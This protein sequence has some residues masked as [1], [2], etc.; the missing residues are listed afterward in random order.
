MRIFIRA[1][2]GNSIGLGHIMR[3]LV[4][5]KEL[6][7]QN[8]QVIYICRDKEKSDKYKTGIQKI[9]EEN[10]QVIKI[11]EN[12]FITEIINIQKDYNAD[13]IITD[14]YDVNEEYFDI[15][16]PYFKLTGYIDDVNKCRM[17]VDFILNQNINANDLDY[18]R[19]VKSKT[20]LFLGTKY[21]LIR[22]EFRKAYKKKIINLEADKILLTLGGMDNNHNTI[23][24]LN[25]MKEINKKI[26]VVIGTA[27]SRELIEK[28][29]YLS[30]ENNNIIPCE[31]ANMSQLML[32]CDAAVSACGST[33]YE[34]AAMKVP[35]I[36]LIVAD[37]QKEV[38]EKMIENS[39][40]VDI[41]DINKFNQ[42]EFLDSVQKC[43][44]DKNLRRSIINKMKNIV[45]INGAENILYEINKFLK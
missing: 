5:A 39:L 41:F 19:N 20:K 36:G 21:C 38:A 15:L 28:I 43:I 30:K 9:I 32:E 12:N 14:S 1:D 44:G 34:L 3:T 31:N 6:R 16:R 10:F 37:N 11:S 13:L 27:F 23:K 25:L 29:N 33:L 22:D 26:Y 18:S 45:D 42:K 4:L 40:L 8:N 35:G 24:I 2:G 7:K 17:N